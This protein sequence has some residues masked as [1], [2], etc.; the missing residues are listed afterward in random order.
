MDHSEPMPWLGGMP[1]QTKMH[2]TTLYVQIHHQTRVVVVVG[3][4]S[5]IRIW[6]MQWFY[7][8]EDGWS[9]SK[10]R[11]RDKEQLQQLVN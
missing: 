4:P 10:E 9:V 2:S 5:S 1:T 7:P 6:S 8:I 11:L 3:Q